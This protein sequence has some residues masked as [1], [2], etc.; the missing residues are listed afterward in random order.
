MQPVPEVADATWQVMYGM[1]DRLDMNKRRGQPG[2]EKR[3]ERKVMEDLELAYLASSI[4]E[5]NLKG[6]PHPVG[7]IQRLIT[8]RKG[9]IIKSLQT[10]GIMNHGYNLVVR[11]PVIAGKKIGNA[12]ERQHGKMAPWMF[13]SCRTY[14][15][16]LMSEGTTKTET[17][18]RTLMAPETASSTRTALQLENEKLQ[19]EISEMRQER[20]VSLW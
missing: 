14:E 20:K 1:W 16:P 3:L 5:R 9:D 10:R 11:P 17:Q 18:G 8:R 12:T 2:W 19:Q 15:F 4:P 7:C 13:Y 6:G